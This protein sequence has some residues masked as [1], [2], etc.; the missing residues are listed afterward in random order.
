M[1]NSTNTMVDNTANNINV[2][3]PNNLPILLSSKNSKEL[4]ISRSMFYRLMDD[5]K[6]LTL[7]IGNRK[8]IHRDRFF[9]WLN[10]GVED[11]DR[12]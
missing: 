6:Q 1:I 9:E 7:T 10:N 12:A 8:F 5:E 4:G 2:I 11:G 3:S